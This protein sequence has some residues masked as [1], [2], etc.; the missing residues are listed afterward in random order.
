MSSVAEVFEKDPIL[1]Y[2][3]VFSDAAEIMLPLIIKVKFDSLIL[4]DYTLSE[5]QCQGLANAISQVGLPKIKI[6]YLDNCGVDDGECAILLEG[7][8]KLDCFH[9]FV[10]KN[11]VFADEALEA[12][13]PILLKPKGTN[14]RVIKFVNCNCSGAIMDEFLEFL[15]DNG[16]RL[17]DLSLVQMNLSGSSVEFLS[18][19]ILTNYSLETLDISWNN[20][21][22]NNFTPL[23]TALAKNRYLKNI[24][25]SWNVVVDTSD[26][27][28]EIEMRMLDRGERMD[29]ERRRMEQAYTS[30]SQ[31]IVDCLSDILRYNTSL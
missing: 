29:N 8:V 26:Q 1:I 16:I 27:H 12:L 5:N 25:L 20:L 17:E 22:A 23:L 2:Q 21:R 7:L 31:H 28:N 9:S 4:Q 15:I 3:K 11:N 18:E 19:Y 6:L 30:P 13:Q 14:L 10:Y 24:N